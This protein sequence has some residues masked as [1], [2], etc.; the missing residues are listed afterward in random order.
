MKKS[1]A[2]R[3]RHL[4]RFI[5]KAALLLAAGLPILLSQGRAEDAPKPDPAGIV[6]GDKSTAVD[7]GATPSRCRPRR[8][9]TRRTIPKTKKILT[10]TSPRRPRNRWR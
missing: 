2:R 5:A 8:T 10:T 6:T 4:F 1:A 9:R 7:A 3:R